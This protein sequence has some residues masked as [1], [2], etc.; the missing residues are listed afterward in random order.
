MSVEVKELLEK[1]IVSQI[2]ALDDAEEYTVSVDDTV[3][4]MDKL[5]EMERL[6][7]DRLDKEKSR[8]L[9]EDLKLKEIA[10]SK[11]DRLWK[12]ALSIGTFAIGTVVT[13]WA[14]VDSK[15]FERGFTQTTEAGRTSTRNILGFLNKFK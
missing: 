14:Y 12:N 4:L 8:R 1:E 10:E 13:I 2:E 5:I 15:E 7:Q 9:E 6:E 3:R 11:K